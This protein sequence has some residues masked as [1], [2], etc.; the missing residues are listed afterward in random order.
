MKREVTTYQLVR[1]YQV[2]SHLHYSHE[3]KSRDAYSHCIAPVVEYQSQ[4][5]CVTRPSCLLAVHLVKHP[6]REEAP[7]LEEDKPRRDIAHQ[8]HSYRCVEYGSRYNSM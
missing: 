8:R 4:S 3:D 7:R 6:I 1:R 5:R 2:I